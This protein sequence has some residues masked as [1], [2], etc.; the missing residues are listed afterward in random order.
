MWTHFVQAEAG[1]I[2]SY[3]GEL[4]RDPERKNE[5]SILIEDIRMLSNAL[6]F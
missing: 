3:L 4:M 2:A 1:K 5:G 6:D